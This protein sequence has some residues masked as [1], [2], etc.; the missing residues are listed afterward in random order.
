MLSS[1]KCFQSN[2]SLNIPPGQPPGHLNFC[3][4]SPLPRLKLF[5]CPIIGPFQ[6]IGCP[7]PQET[8]SFYYAPEAV[9]VN[10]SSMENTLTCQRYYKWFLNT[11]TYRTKLVQA[12][13]FQPLRHES[14]I[15]RFECIKACLCHDLSSQVES[16]RH[17]MKSRLEI[18]FPTALRVVIKC[19]APGK[20]KLIKFPSS[21]AVKDVKCP[22]YV[23]GDA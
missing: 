12:F 17:N 16:A 1:C 4:N 8:F 21:G 6:V 3:S 18:K 10:M 20:T 11:F 22:G 7:H 5:K 14:G 2:R 15:F 19:L 9:Y 23:L 13:A